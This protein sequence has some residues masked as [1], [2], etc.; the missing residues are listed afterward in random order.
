[1]DDPEHCYCNITKDRPK[2]GDSWACAKGDHS[3]CHLHYSD[4]KKL[5]TEEVIERMNAWS[6][7][8]KKH[9]VLGSYPICDDWKDGS[10]TK[11]WLKD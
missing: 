10:E 11:P 3:D 1:V 6:D 4:G 8:S 9:E 2:S 7:W 5:S